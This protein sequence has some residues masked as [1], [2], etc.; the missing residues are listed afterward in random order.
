MTKEQKITSLLK[1]DPLTG[2]ITR[3]KTGKVVETL[4]SKGYVQVSLGKG[5]NVLGHRA[6]WFLLHGEWPDQIDHRN[7]VRNDNRESNLR[8]V[9][10]EENRRSHHVS[11]GRDSDLPIGITRIIRPNKIYFRASARRGDK[12]IERA[13]TTLEKAIQN[14]AEIRE[15]IADFANPT[16]DRSKES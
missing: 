8:N 12:K 9:T 4:T 13:S 2:E 16:I 11:S 15:L 3:I 1:Y 6:I 5:C 7:G 10:R 14:L